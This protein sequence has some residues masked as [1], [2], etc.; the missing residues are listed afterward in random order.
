M[1]LIMYTSNLWN[2]WWW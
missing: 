1:I 2:K